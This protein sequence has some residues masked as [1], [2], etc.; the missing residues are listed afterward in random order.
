MTGLTSLFTPPGLTENV[1]AIVVARKS[2]RIGRPR[3]KVEVDKRHA[4]IK[5]AQRRVARLLK[6]VIP[7]GPDAANFRTLDVVK[8]YK[9]EMH[10]W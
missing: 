1:V 8:S 6:E 7:A 2:R 10:L 5:A 4:A 9:D 3:C